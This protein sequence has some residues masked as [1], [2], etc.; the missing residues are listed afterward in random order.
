MHTLSL[1]LY[2]CPKYITLVWLWENVKPN[3]DI[4]QENWPSKVPTLFKKQ[5]LDCSRL[6]ETKETRQ[7]NAKCGPKVG[8]GPE[9]KKG[10]FRNTG[11]IWIKSLD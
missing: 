5:G 3:L 6:E 4:L 11:E 9:K 7:L 8:P 2:S 1:L 10:Y